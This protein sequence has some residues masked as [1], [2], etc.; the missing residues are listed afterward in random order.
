M[1]RFACRCGHILTLSEGW[2]DDELLLIPE[3]VVEEV[4]DMIEGDVLRS[5]DALCA[6][7]DRVPPVSELDVH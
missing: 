4:A 7:I 3:P 2:S 6:E 1:S 5:S